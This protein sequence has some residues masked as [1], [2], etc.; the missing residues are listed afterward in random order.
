MK[1]LNITI[2]VYE[3]RINDAHVKDL[4]KPVTITKKEDSAIKRMAKRINRGASQRGF[5]HDGEECVSL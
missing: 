4:M 1:P 3:N 5:S 2:E